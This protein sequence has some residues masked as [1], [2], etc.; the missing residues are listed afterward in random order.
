MEKANKIHPK[1]GR[2]GAT[3]KLEKYRKSVW[4]RKFLWHLAESFLG[5]LITVG[6]HKYVY[7]CEDKKFKSNW[8]NWFASGHSNASQRLDVHPGTSTE[9]QPLHGR[10]LL[11]LSDLVWKINVATKS[12]SDPH[13]DHH[14]PDKTTLPMKGLISWFVFL[15][16]KLHSTDHLTFSSLGKRQQWKDNA[17]NL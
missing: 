8:L 2:G 13:P 16:A 15:T 1:L 3:L 11:W 12:F 5:H 7:I 14:A 9:S 6:T 4:L 17:K 10:L